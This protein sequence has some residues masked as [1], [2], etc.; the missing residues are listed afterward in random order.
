MSRS[1]WD[2]IGLSSTEN[3]VR[4]NIVVMPAGIEPATSSLEGFSRLFSS[5]HTLALTLRKS[6]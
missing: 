1:D 3:T 6:S 2:D 4:T 5:N